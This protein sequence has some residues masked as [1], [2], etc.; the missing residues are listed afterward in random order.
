MIRTVRRKAAAAALAVGAAGGLAATLP[1]S[2]A[3]AYFSPPL[4]LD[5]EV[6]SPAYVI[7]KGAGVNVPVEVTCNP[8]VAAEYYVRLTQNVNGKI[9]SGY[10]YGSTRCTGSHQTVLVTVVAAQG[11]AFTKGKAL[12]SAETFACLGRVCGTETDSR[13]VTLRK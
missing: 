6:Q 8:G 9:A 3:V 10:G 7:A 4:F 12:A 5:I 13:T 2:P 11:K 1:A